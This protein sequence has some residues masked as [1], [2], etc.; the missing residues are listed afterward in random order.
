LYLEIIGPDG[1]KFDKE[2]ASTIKIDVTDAGVGAWKY[3]VTAKKVPY[4]NFPFTLTV[5]QK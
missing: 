3:T 5:W 1:R 2:G 4:E